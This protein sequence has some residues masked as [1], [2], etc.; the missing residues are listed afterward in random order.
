VLHDNLAGQPVLLPV[1]A[2]GLAVDAGP[3]RGQGQGSSLVQG[4]AETADLQQFPASPRE[5]LTLNS[6]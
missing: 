4:L 5:K 1:L 3:G 2:C 6:W